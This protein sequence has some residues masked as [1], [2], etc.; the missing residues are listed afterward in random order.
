LAA[1]SVCAGALSLLFSALA[2]RVWRD[3]SERSARQMF[4]YSLFYLFRIFA[5][6]LVDRIAGGLA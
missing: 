5:L 4:T 1:A 3:D 2:I 6:L